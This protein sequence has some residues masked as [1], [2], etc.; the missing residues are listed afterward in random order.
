M[1]KKAI[2]I[3]PYILVTLL[4][5]ISAIFAFQKSIK[6]YGYDRTLNVYKKIE[7][8]RPLKYVVIGDSIGRGAGAEHPDLRWFKIL[9]RKM[10]AES[11]SRM[12]GEY[13]V[14]SG[15][16]AFEG[17]NKLSKAAINTKTDLVFI[18]FGENDR[19]YMTSSDF[20]IFYESLI[21]KAKSIYPS[22]EIL[23]ITES[24]LKYPDFA[25]VIAR[26]S[27]HY[28]AAHVDMRPI[29]QK[30]GLPEKAL[31]A[32]LI[33][34]NGKGYQL[35]A[36]TVYRRLMAGLANQ[37]QIAS[38][39]P[40]LNIETF[41]KYVTSN[42]F[43]L[44]KGFSYKH[45]L[46]TSNQKGSVL[47]ADFNGNILGVKVLRSPSGG[48]VNVYIDGR[49]KTKL[50]TWWPFPRERQ[51][52][53]ANGLSPGSHTVRFEFLGEKMRENHAPVPQINISSIIVN[54]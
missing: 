47:E 3:V 27:A 50:N 34:P 40:S 17:L 53:I 37:K 51:L 30:S 16:T 19:K 11:G 29:F 23:T 44:N 24:C 33:H 13:F 18:V 35:Y 28:Q 48:V 49:F 42:H 21:R 22:A 39:K 36:D 31:T 45:G 1:R 15:A 9:E 20:S 10:F 41:E 8:Q 5:V 2:K 32:D 46:F 12:A 6:T 14:Q 25:K 52:Y 4:I 54:K 7:Q 26:L 43:H 38:L